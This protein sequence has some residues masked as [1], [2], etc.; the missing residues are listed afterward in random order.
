MW[1]T[2]G[3]IRDSSTFISMSF[4][5]EKVVFGI[6]GGRSHKIIS[7][8]KRKIGFVSYRNKK[9]KETEVKCYKYWTCTLPSIYEADKPYFWS[10]VPNSLCDVKLGHVCTKRLMDTYRPSTVGA[11]SSICSHAFSS[12]DHQ[13][14]MLN[15]NLVFAMNGM[16]EVCHTLKGVGWSKKL[17]LHNF[18]MTNFFII[19]VALCKNIW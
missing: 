19:K 16:L 17:V 6:A 10:W 15:S 5:V 3:I 8:L 7:L 14:L 9:A 12:I 13:H 18:P 11:H 1:K 2:A 4:S